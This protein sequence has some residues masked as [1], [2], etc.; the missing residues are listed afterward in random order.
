MTGSDNDNRKW[1]VSSI[2]VVKNTRLVYCT[3]RVA[4]THTR[5]IRSWFVKGVSLKASKNKIYG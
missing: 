2:G 1:T 4:L 3:T 5:Q